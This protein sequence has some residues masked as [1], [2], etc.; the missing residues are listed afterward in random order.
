MAR[1]KKHRTG[2]SATKRVASKM[3]F[4]VW[5]VIALTAVLA[6]LVVLSIWL[7]PRMVERVQARADSKNS[8]EVGN[9]ATVTGPAVQNVAI[10]NRLDQTDIDQAAEQS[11]RG[12]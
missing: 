1:R 3:P 11:N 8:N 10:T 12:T 9:T 4:S 6:A 2:K 5:L 7:R